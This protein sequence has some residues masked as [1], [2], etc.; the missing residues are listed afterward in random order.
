MPAY[1][2]LKELVA[3]YLTPDQCTF[4]HKAYKH[5]KIAHDGVTRASGEPYITHPIA[6]AEILANMQLDHESIAAALLHDVIEDTPITQ[7]EIKDHFNSTVA[8][9]VQGMTKLAKVDFRNKEQAQAE[10]I[11]KMLIAMS[12]DFRIML[13]KL[14]D[15][16]HNMR[17]LQSLRPEKRYRIAQETIDIFTPIAERL[18]LHTL[19]TELEDLAFHAQHPVRYNV[20]RAAITRARGNR[21]DFLQQM[22]NE[23]SEK[24]KTAGIESKV[25]GREKHLYSL[26]KKMQRKGYNFHDV[27]D[28][29]AFRVIVNDLDTCYRV[30][31][32]IHHLYKPK[33]DLFKDYIALP[34][35]NSYQSIHSTLVT[36]H[37]VNIEIQIRTIAMDNVAKHGIAAHWSYKEGEKNVNVTAKLQTRNWFQGLADSTD[38]ATN[39]LVLLENLKQELGNNEVHVLTPQGEIIVLPAQATPVD[40]A[41]ALHTDIGH[42]CK[43]AKVDGEF[44]MLTSKL[45]SGQTVQIL[46]SQRTKPNAE[47]LNFVA[48]HRAR[49]A[50]R[51]YLKQQPREVAIPA[52]RRLLKQALNTTSITEISQENIDRV[53]KD[54]NLNSIDDLLNDIGNGKIMSIVIARLLRGNTREL[55]ESDMR[56]ANRQSAIKGTENMMISYAKCCRPLPGDEIVAHVTP[57]KGIVVHIRNCY[58]VSNLKT[59]PDKYIS[60]EWDDYF[61]SQY[62][63][64]T[65]LNIVMDHHKMELMKLLTEIAKS[66]ANIVEI[67][68]TE[69]TDAI[70]L[71]NIKLNV[72]NRIHLSRVMRKLKNIPHVKSI[73]RNSPKGF[74]ERRKSTEKQRKIKEQK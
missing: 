36:H 53:V 74:I 72:L 1:Q 56:Q 70:Y 6:V 65:I 43:G 16:V 69:Q 37:G 49:N 23:I 10:N 8:D 4:I 7:N 40:F 20:L 27:M 19:K 58:A 44:S 63:Y 17:T 26:Y 30:L 2:K 42:R 66:N 38:N 48:T 60:V 21:K 71:V 54:Q 46:L 24:L 67:Q 64:T 25:L 51:H 18:G 14:A 35:P 3:S 33:V 62:E 41:Y 15:R 13:I 45:E 47:W 39:S 9:L 57:N 50:I 59:E 11:R 34:K 12:K 31:G 5:A 28:I 55:T 68:T 73:K 61:F 32:Q 22:C 29:Y 52:G